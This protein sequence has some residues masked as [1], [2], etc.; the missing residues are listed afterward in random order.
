MLGNWIPDSYM[1]N[2]EVR[3]LSNTIH[4]VSSKWTNDLNVRPDSTKLSEENAGRTVFDKNR[5]N[6]FFDPLLRVMKI[7]IEINKWDLIKLKSFCMT[8]KT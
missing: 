4:K 6:I 8:K 7:K 1:K 3:T 2:I 5:S